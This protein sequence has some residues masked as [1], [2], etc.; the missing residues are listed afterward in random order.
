[1]RS[2]PRPLKTV[3]LKLLLHFS[4]EIFAFN[5]P[6]SL[7]GTG[8]LLLPAS[9]AAGLQ[10]QAFLSPENLGL[11]SGVFLAILPSAGFALA[12]LLQHRFRARQY[13]LY[14]NHGL[15]IGLCY[16]VAWLTHCLVVTGLTLL[17]TIAA[18]I[19]AA[20]TGS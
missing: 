17:T 7:L 2:V 4:V 10:G 20:V 5:L 11:Y 13:P 12:S 19:A 18:T 8:A 6:V 3:H 14:L 15:R 16:L 1:M 9:L